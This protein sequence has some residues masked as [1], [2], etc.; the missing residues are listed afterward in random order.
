MIASESLALAHDRAENV[1]QF[2][3]LLNESIALA[4]QTLIR[5]LD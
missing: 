1:H 3:R 2:L 4:R 5:R